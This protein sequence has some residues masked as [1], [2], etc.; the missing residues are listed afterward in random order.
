[1]I[2]IADSSFR[3]YSARGV[4][5]LFLW[6]VDEEIPQKADGKHASEDEIED[7]VETKED[8]DDSLRSGCG[9]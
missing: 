9:E 7:E 2:A 4:F 6:E 3:V 1:M 5:A 8:I